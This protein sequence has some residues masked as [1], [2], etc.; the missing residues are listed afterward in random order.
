MCIF[1]YLYIFVP[2]CVHMYICMNVYIY[3]YTFIYTYVYIHVCVCMCVCVCV[4]HGMYVYIYIYIYIYNIYIYIYIYIMCLYV[5]MCARSEHRIYGVA[6]LVSSVFLLTFLENQSSKRGIKREKNCT[7]FYISRYYTSSFVFSMCIFG[8]F[9][10]KFLVVYL[11]FRDIG[12][13]YPGSDIL[14]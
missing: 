3:I 13:K 6:F 12:S 2:I 10:V 8:N 4:C 5:C 11:E 7:S 9:F 1:V 14:Q